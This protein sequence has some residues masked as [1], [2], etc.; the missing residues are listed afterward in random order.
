[1]NDIITRGD[2][3]KVPEQELDNKTAWYIPHHGVYHPHKPEKIRVVFDCSAR[4]RGTSLNDHLLTGPDLTNTLVGVLCR[5]R[6][7][8]IAIMCDVERMFHQFHVI[9][10]HQDYLRFLWW[11]KGDLN[12]KPSVYRMKVHL[13]GAASSPGCCNF[14]LKHIA[15]QGRNTFS[16]ETVEFIQRGFYVDDGLASVTSTAKAIQLVK[17][18]REL[19]KTGNLHLHK[20]VSN[21]KEVLATIPQEEQ[22]QSKDQ[23]MALGELHIERALGV[24]WCIEADEFQFRVQVKDNPLTRRGVLSTV[25]S[26]YDPLGFV[27]PFTLIG[28]QILQTLCKDKVN[29]DDDLPDHILPRWE[30]WL[31]DLPKLAALKIPRSYSQDINIIQYELHNFSDASLD[32]YGA[33]SYLRA[34]SKEGRISCSLVMGKARVTP[35]KQMTIP[36]LELSSAVTS[37][38]NADVIKQELEI[39]NLLEYYWT[40]SQVV[41]A[42]ISNDAKRFHTFVANRIQ[43]I[44]QSTSPE[45][46]QH[47]SSEENPADQ[48][49]RGLTAAQLKESNWLKGPDFLWKKDL[50]IKKETVGEVEEI[51]P[52]L[53]AGHAHTMRSKEVNPILERLKKF[54]DW[55]RAIKAIARLKRCLK[56]FKGVQERT[57]KTTDLEERRDIEVFI[58]KLVQREAFTEEIQKIRSQKKNH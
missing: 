46:W 19:C 56:E 15:S 44:R 21:N 6:K 54:S 7:G 20:F 35:I 38:R 13:F 40:D 37:V 10:E 12:S 31:R 3:E 14:G 26:I 23:N 58:I 28:K 8:P 1:M 43:R 9:K 17:E 39:E 16:K 55:S 41:L 29:W 33:C 52:E 32:G 45:K 22:A 42:Y 30:A 11:D 5:F 25:A 18:S 50:P 27:A 24:Q 34:I 36:R 57:N 51:D 2:A 48:A 49:S 53:R 47:V 4:F